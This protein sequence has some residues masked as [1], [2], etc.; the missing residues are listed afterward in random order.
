MKRIFLNIIIVVSI[1]CLNVANVLAKEYSDLTTNHWAYK[2]IEALSN[3]DIVVGYPDGTFK[4]DSNVTRAEFATMVVKAVGQENADLKEIINFEDINNTYWAWNM[5]QRAVRFDIVKKSSDNKFYPEN[6]VTKAQAI[7]FV[8]NALD[9][10]DISI[11]QAKDAL[12][13]KYY[14]YAAIPDWIL[15][16]AGKAEF[17]GMIPNVP[18]K[19]GTLDVEKPATRAELAVFLYNLKEQVK[20]NANKKLKAALK[21]RMADGFIVKDA[22]V[23]KN[24]ATIPVGTILPVKLSGEISSQKSKLGEVFVATFPQNIVTKE[25]YL[26][27]NEGVPLTGQVLDLNVARYFWRNGAVILETK[28]LKTPGNQVAKFSTLADTDVQ[29][30]GFWKK[31]KRMIIRGEKYELQAGDIVNVKTLQPVRIDIVTGRFVEN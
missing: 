29:V 6:T 5:I 9:T 31:V 7:A 16:P 22:V 10:D 19:S 28:S 21:P 2:Q 20:I 17:L 30:S 18:G 3:E 11:S 27:I 23:D 24:I 15:I 26:L 8:I 13:K 4:P 12:L 1:F 14:D 25:H